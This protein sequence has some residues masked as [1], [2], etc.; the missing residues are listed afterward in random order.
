MFNNNLLVFHRLKMGEDPMQVPLYHVDFWVQ[1]HNLSTGLMS[2]DLY[3]GSIEKEE[4]ITLSQNNCIY[5]RFQYERLIVFHFFSRQLG[6][7]EGFYPGRIMHGK[8]ELSFEWDLS[9]KVLPRRAMV[10]KS[11]LLRQER[12]DDIKGLFQNLAF[13]RNVGAYLGINLGKNKEGNR[14]NGENID[15]DVSMGVECLMETR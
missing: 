11:F 1:I 3:K 5:T 6:H 8:K 13:L 2:E 12:D 10:A 9:I 14:R 7:V 15:P 4:K